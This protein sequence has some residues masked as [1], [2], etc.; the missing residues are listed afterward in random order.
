[1]FRICNC[2]DSNGSFTNV[3]QKVVEMSCDTF[4]KNRL[5]DKHDRY[6]EMTVKIMCI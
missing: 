3:I 4:K 1:M 5:N 2:F 6:I